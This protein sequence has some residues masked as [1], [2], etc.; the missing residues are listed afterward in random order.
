MTH[1]KFRRICLIVGSLLI[2]SIGIAACS[3]EP[4]T[5]EVTRIV[6]VP[7]EIEV[8]AET[9]EVEVPVEVTRVV[10]VMVEPEVP[11]MAMSVIPFEE[12]WASSPH[13]AADA[14]AFVH[15][16]ADDPAEVPANCAK[17]HSTTGFMDFVGADGSAFGSVE[18]AVP[19]GE[20]I[21]CQACH[22]DATQDLASV[23]FPSG[24]EVTGL[25]QKHVV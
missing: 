2:F 21:E 17:C 14:E 8:P 19:V 16:D 22:N 13:A 24:V 3:Q 5:V 4:E 20:V 6:E 9:V 12:Q 23:T 25:G 11:E 18:T 15:W 10:E 1:P 7:V